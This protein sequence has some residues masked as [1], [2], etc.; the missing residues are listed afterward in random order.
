[1]AVFYLNFVH[2]KSFIYSGFPKKL[3][4]WLQVSPGLFYSY[5]LSPIMKAGRRAVSLN[6]IMI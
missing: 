3:R 5:C 1:M 6:R 2:E 4:F